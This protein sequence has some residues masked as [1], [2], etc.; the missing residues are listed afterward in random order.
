MF[1]GKNGMNGKAEAVPAEST[2]LARRKIQFGLCGFYIRWLLP[3]LAWSPRSASLCATQLIKNPPFRLIF[4]VSYALPEG[5][6]CR[7]TFTTLTS[8]KNNRVNLCL[9]R[10]EKGGALR[11]P[12]REGGIRGEPSCVKTAKTEPYF[13]RKRRGGETTA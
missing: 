2:E 1:Y 4:E 12:F 8:P 13:R 9:D 11:A 3:P 7:P 10:E 6:S 5:G